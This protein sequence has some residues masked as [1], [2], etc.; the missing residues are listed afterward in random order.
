MSEIWACCRPCS[1][2]CRFS[3]NWGVGGRLGSRLPQRAVDYLYVIARREDAE[4]PHTGY[5]LIK[6]TCQ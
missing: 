3:C 6:Y 4:P 5:P 1:D 2:A